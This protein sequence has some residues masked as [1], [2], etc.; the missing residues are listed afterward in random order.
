M[1]RTVAVTPDSYVVRVKLTGGTASEA[2]YVKLYNRR[3][4]E[5]REVRED[6]DTAAINAADASSDGTKFGTF[7]GWENGDVLDIRVYGAKFGSGS[8]TIATGKG[9]GQITVTV[10]DTT[11]TNTPGVS[12]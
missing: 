11:A 7:S 12:I 1:P 9:G 4:G 5:Y 10:A 2:C 3:T 6:Q 8:H